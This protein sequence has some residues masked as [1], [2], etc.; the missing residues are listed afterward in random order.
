MEWSFVVALVALAIGALAQRTVG[1]G[2]GLVVTPTMVLAVGPVEA[3][4]VVNVFGIV[5]CAMIIGRVWRDIDWRGLVWLV[6][7]AIAL[8]IPGILL[9]Q[10]SDADALK[11]AVG[12][13]ALVGV[14]VSAGFAKTERSLDGPPLRMASGAL[15]GA[16]NSSVG[17]GAPVI[18][19]FAILSKWD[20][21]VFAATMQPFWILLSLSTVVSRQLVAP[22]GAPPWEWW[23]WLVA[24]APVLVGVL[25]GERIAARIDQAMARRAVI[26]FSLLSGIAVL[27][28]GIV[29]LAS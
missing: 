7:P 6:L 28:T 14:V 26:V 15:V 11:V 23:M 9:A 3:V 2:F 1:M 20:H 4:L 5:A 24:I 21:R 8:T 13:L 19:M 17:L 16:L 18:G 25:A 12:V 29:G 27:V 22:G 10:A